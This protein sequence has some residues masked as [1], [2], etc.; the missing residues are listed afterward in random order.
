MVPKCNVKELPSVPKH[1]RAV[2]CL[3]KTVYVLAKFHSDMIY[4]AIGCGFNVNEL[5]IY[6]TLDVIKQK[7]T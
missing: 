7:Q 5:T 4:G 1:R 2:M 6:I 3:M